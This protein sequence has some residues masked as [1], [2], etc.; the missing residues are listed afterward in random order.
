MTK[1]T[2]V[3]VYLSSILKQICL[4]LFVYMWLFVCL[5]VCMFVCL[6]VACKCRQDE[7]PTNWDN[8]KAIQFKK[9]KISGFEN[10]GRLY[11]KT[12]G[13]VFLAKHWKY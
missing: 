8:Y 2:P 1:P 5:F 12:L 10:C 3:V 7:G 9:I 4:F 6:F 13:T 11:N